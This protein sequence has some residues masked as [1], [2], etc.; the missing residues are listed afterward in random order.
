MRSRLGWQ[1]RVW[2]ISRRISALWWLI[3]RSSKPRVFLLDR[4][5]LLYIAVA[6]PLILYCSLVHGVVF[7]Q[8]YEFLPL[9]FV[10]S[11]SALGVVGSWL[12]FQV[13]YFTSWDG[14]I[15]TSCNASHHWC[16]VIRRRKSTCGG[17][18]PYTNYSYCMKISSVH[19]QG[20]HT[21]TAG[22]LN[23]HDLISGRTVK[24][25]R[26]RTL[27]ASIQ[28]SFS[29]KISMPKSVLYWSGNK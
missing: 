18:W 13:V 23:D 15:I 10:S 14:T 8:K 27:Q 5:S 6:I 11:Y 24:R 16:R 21:M 28:L 3:T 17:L 19:W 7:G 12:G 9:M 2:N 22:E 1:C 4:F 29:M 20:H 26:L 25:R